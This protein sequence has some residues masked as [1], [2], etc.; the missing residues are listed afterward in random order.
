MNVGTTAP[1]ASRQPC[2]VAAHVTRDSVIRGYRYFLFHIYCCHWTTP[3]PKKGSHQTFGNNNLNLN[4]FSKFFHCW[5]EDEYFQQN[6]VA[7]FFGTRCISYMRIKIQN[8]AECILAS[9]CLW[10]TCSAHM[11]LAL[12]IS[13]RGSK[14]SSLFNGQVNQN[15]RQNTHRYRQYY[16]A[17]RVGLFVCDVTVMPVTDAVTLTQLTVL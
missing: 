8:F 10:L 15:T 2:K 9:I 14:L 1:Q 7:F 13:A 4:R 3:C 11:W 17:Y 6:C 16:H 12:M 5:K